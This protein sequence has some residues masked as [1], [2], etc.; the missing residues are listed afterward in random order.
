MDRNNGS[1]VSFCVVTNCLFF[2]IVVVAVV[3]LCK[4]SVY[5]GLD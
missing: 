1:F 2:V 3:V 4:F 5:T